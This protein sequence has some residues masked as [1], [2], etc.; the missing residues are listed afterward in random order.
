MDWIL[1]RAMPQRRVFI[2]SVCFSDADDVAAIE[3]SQGDIAETLTRIEAASSELG[4]HISWSKTKIQNIGAGPVAPDLLINGQVVEGVDKFVYL[5]ST[6]C[7]A[8]GSRSEQM[9]RIGF[10]TAKHAQ[11]SLHLE[12]GPPLTGYKITPVC[13]LNCSHTALRL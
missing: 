8:D 5:G 12:S 10:P 4:L 13:D 7:S 3:G 11:S 9:R 2:S 1:S 6:V